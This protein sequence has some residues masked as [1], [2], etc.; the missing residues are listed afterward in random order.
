MGYAENTSVSVARTRAEIED[1]IT[2]AGGR[3]FTSSSK[4]DGTAVLIFEMGEGKGLR[5]IMFELP[6]PAQETFKTREV[7]RAWGRVVTV[8][9]TL[10]QQ[11]KAWEQACRTSWR[12]LFLAIKAK[13]TS[14]EVGIETFEMAF[15]AQ[16][17]VPHDGRMEMFG[18]LA[19]KALAKAYLDGGAVKLPLL[20]AGNG[21]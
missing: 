1:L 17:V 7:R 3:R 4:D 5:R 21:S 16:V 13:L 12:S 2:R 20:T 18:K 15:L 8:E 11:M 19:G 14:V 6:L 9:C 10:E